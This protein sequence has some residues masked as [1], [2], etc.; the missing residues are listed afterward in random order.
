MGCGNCFGPRRP[1]DVCPGLARPPS[2][3][4]EEVIAVDDAASFPVAEAEE[5]EPLSPG[6]PE[7]AGDALDAEHARAREA[8]SAFLADSQKVAREAVP[9][10]CALAESTL[11]RGLCV[12]LDALNTTRSAGMPLPR[13]ACELLRGSRSVCE[14]MGLSIDQGTR[15]CRNL[16]QCID[17]LLYPLLERGIDLKRQEAQTAGTRLEISKCTRACRE[18]LIEDGQRLTEQ[19]PQRKHGAGWQPLP[20]VCACVRAALL[21]LAWLSGGVARE[22]LEPSPGGSIP[23]NALYVS[24]INHMVGVLRGTAVNPEGGSGTRVETVHGFRGVVALLSTFGGLLAMSQPLVEEEDPL[25]WMQH[26]PFFALDSTAK[27]LLLYAVA[28]IQDSRPL[29]L[30]TLPRA[31]PLEAVMDAAHPVYS[32]GAGP[33]RMNPAFA[34]DSGDGHGARK[35]LFELVALE[36]GA[37]WQSEHLSSAFNAVASVHEGSAHV[38]VKLP[39]GAEP[40]EGLCPRCRLV[41]R[42]LGEGQEREHDLVRIPDPYEM[43]C[44]QVDCEGEGILRL[45]C[46][47]ISPVTADLVDFAFRPPATPCFSSREGGRGGSWWFNPRVTEPRAP[48]WVARY[49]FAGWLM[50]AAIVSNVALPLALPPVF[51]TMLRQWPHYEP[52]SDHLVALEGQDAVLRVRALSDEELREAA[53]LQ[54]LPEDTDREGYIAHLCSDMLDAQVRPQMNALAEGFD[55]Q[56]VRESLCFKHCSNH[57]LRTLIC[58]RHEPSLDAEVNIRCEFQIEYDGGFRSNPQSEAMLEV[59]WDVLDGGMADEESKERKAIPGLSLKR[60]F[61][62]F[63]TGR[64][65]L[66]ALPLDDRLRFILMPAPRSAK[67]AAA[68]LE[69]L[70]VAHTCDN[71]LQLPNYAAAVLFA[72]GS[73]YYNL[74]GKDEAVEVTDSDIASGWKA[75]GDADPAEQRALRARLVHV[76]RER[77]RLSVL[78]TDSIDLG[79]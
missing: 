51:F 48:E 39:P 52:L 78:S 75:V 45:R 49:T 11:I 13:D 15:V 72:P 69:R 66:P 7:V 59:L 44:L 9:R 46:D 20:L 24:S 43:I 5:R 2:D 36:L 1:E 4:G 12:R 23:A 31:D 6:T 8:L 16:G 17:T 73:P 22:A 50:G 10:L 3:P 61:L 26:L 63:M 64:P 28:S 30:A 21:A 18:A 42:G 55:L 54:S 57:E 14:R 41:F 53:R 74:P 79:E 67:E 65:R 62:K 29:S 70:P 76:L 37:E 19:A 56:Q 58:G 40:P 71:S 33:V 38:L 25:A 32:S 27:G 77:L 47:R 34:G 35:E 60:R 68:V